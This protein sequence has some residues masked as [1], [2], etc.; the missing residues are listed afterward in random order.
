MRQVSS[1]GACRS[2]P[3]KR[4]VVLCCR[5]EGQ[6]M[7]KQQAQVDHGPKSECRRLNVTFYASIKGISVCAAVNCKESIKQ[8]SN[9]SLRGWLRRAQRGVAYEKC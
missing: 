4:R 1:S 8:I 5:A 9:G 6:E 3:L 2:V 7:P